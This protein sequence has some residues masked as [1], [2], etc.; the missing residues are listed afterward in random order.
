MA[1]IINFPIKL[2][3]RILLLLMRHCLQS[4]GNGM[5]QYYVLHRTLKFYSRLSLLKS[6]L[7]L[8]PCSLKEK[9]KEKK[10]KKPQ[11]IN[12][13]DS[14]LLRACLVRYKSQKTSKLGGTKTQQFTLPRH[15][16][17]ATVTNSLQ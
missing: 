17:T 7:V 14:I 3:L 12:Q 16:L 6:L 9:R 4:T 15:V 2:S 1:V 11:C 13:I 8:H 5:T 10:K